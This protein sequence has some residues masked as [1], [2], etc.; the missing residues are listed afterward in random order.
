[1]IES[2]PVA[3]WMYLRFVDDPEQALITAASTGHDSDTIAAMTGALMGARH[4]TGWIPDRWLHELEYRDELT[5]L[6]D[7]LL[8]IPQTRS[9]R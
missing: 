7:R 2:L 1:M 8:D 9:P 4:G 3:V 6:A 5:S